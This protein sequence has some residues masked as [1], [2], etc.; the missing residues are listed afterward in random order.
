MLK[1]AAV[2]GILLN[3]ETGEETEVDLS[4]LFCCL[5]GEPM[6]DGPCDDPTCDKDHSEPS[7]EGECTDPNCDKEH[8]E[9]N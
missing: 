5:G 8:P 7:E 2:V 9:A 1:F 3:K 6:D 4:G